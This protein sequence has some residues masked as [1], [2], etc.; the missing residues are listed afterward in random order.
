[1]KRRRP[2]P[3]SPV[4]ERR[5]AKQIWGWMKLVDDGM[6]GSC[7][8]T[9]SMRAVAHGEVIY[10]SIDS[11]FPVSICAATLFLLRQQVSG[12]AVRRAKIWLRCNSPGSG[13]GFGARKRSCC[14]CCGGRG[15]DRRTSRLS[16]ARA[17]L[18][19]LLN[20]A[21]APGCP[22]CRVDARPPMDKARGVGSNCP[23]GRRW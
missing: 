12:V 17:P 22:R 21:Q 4:L 14:C 13:S 20:M 5:T 6:D 9:P 8:T 7:C 2:C 1:M 15:R 18:Y 23:L 11:E 10:L 16:R 19:A 3:R